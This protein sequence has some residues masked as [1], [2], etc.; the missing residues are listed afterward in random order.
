MSTSAKPKPGLQA[1]IE[2]HKLAVA[3]FI[4]QTTASLK[5]LGILPLLDQHFADGLTEEELIE[6]LS[7]DDYTI[8]T[9]L[10]A[11]EAFGVLEKN[12]NRWFL[13]KLGFF[14]LNDPLVK[15]NFD[16]TRDICY[17]GLS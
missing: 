9:L 4:F 11:G 14:L 1:L 6:T 12:E 2:A 15:V 13:S 17:E 3:P 8:Q 5:D 16:F 10:P 7:L